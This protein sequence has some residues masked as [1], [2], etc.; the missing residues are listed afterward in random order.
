MA[1]DSCL[2]DEFVLCFRKCNGAREWISDNMIAPSPEYECAA[3]GQ[4][5]YRT[6]D[7]RWIAFH[8]E[9]CEFIMMEGDGVKI[10]VKN[11]PCRLNFC[12]LWI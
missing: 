12:V 8:H 11:E 5:Q 10:S 6:F 7:G 1:T 3:Y 4:D 9:R 2:R